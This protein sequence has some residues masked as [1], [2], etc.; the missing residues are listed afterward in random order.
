MKWLFGTTTFHIRE[1][2]RFELQKANCKY[3]MKREKEMKRKKKVMIETHA[4]IQ[5][6]A[7]AA[8]S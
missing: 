4:F 1:Y 3:E 6:V 7:Q 2:S 5:E 8:H